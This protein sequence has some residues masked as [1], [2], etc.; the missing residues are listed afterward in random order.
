MKITIEPT[1]QCFMAGDVMVRMWRGVDDNGTPLAALVTA[2]SFFETPKDDATSG[3]I[4][5][6]P[7]TNEDALRWADLI[8]RQGGVDNG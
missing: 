4:S 7:P 8:I 5:I 2:I 6:P 3:L 1:E